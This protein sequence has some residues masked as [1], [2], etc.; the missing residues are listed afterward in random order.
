MQPHRIFMVFLLMMLAAVAL[1]AD[2][3]IG[4]KLQAISVNVSCPGNGYSSGGVQG[5][6]TVVIAEVGGK[7]TTWIL[8]A[9]H[10][11]ENLRDIKDV[12]GSDGEARKQ[13]R[14]RDAQ[15]IQEQV[16]AGRGVGEVKYDARIVCVDPRRDIALLR[17]RLDKFTEQGVAFYLDESI[18]Q[19]GTTVYHCGAPG[20]KEIGGTC[21]LTAGIVSRLGV[22]IP[23]FGGAEHGVFDQTDTAALGGSSG[24]LIALKDDGRWIGMI[25]LGLSGG[26]NFHWMVPVRSVREW[27][28]QVGVEWL[29]DPNLPRPSEADL[30]KIPLELNPPGFAKTSREAPTPTEERPQHVIGTHD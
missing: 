18:P 16:Q 7:P 15:I 21:S 6:G 14:Y 24:G 28:K 20:G 12:I 4:P 29:L 2:E 19:P 17:V 10:V 27:A 1:A 23:E 22:R 30:E 3:P 25:T 8:T 11:V 9:H 5:S 26:D 13:V